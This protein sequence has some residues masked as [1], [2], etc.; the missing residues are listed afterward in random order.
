MGVE[1]ESKRTDHRLIDDAR[2]RGVHLSPELVMEAW[3]EM[4]RVMWLHKATVEEAYSKALNW[5]CKQAK[6]Q[7]AAGRAVQASLF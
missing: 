4:H 1:S 5:A 7:A 3:R 2:A 6:K